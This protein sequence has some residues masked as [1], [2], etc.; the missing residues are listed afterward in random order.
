[1]GQLV[2]NAFPFA[3]S[4]QYGSWVRLLQALI[5]WCPGVQRSILPSILYDLTSPFTKGK[6]K[7]P[8]AVSAVSQ[9][10]CSGVQISPYVHQLSTWWEPAPVCCLQANLCAVCKQV[11][12]LLASKCVCCLQANLC[13]VSKQVHGYQVAQPAD[14]P[15]ITSVCRV[16]TYVHMCTVHTQ[17]TSSRDVPNCTVTNS[18]YE[19]G[20]G[21]PL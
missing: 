8:A 10:W 18:G 7:S 6:L 19:H 1:M 17:D 21:Q 3:P 14:V 5:Q 16:C 11:C 12:L 20:S 13:A 4:S 9:G 2:A 15:L